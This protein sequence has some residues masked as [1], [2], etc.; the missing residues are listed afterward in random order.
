MRTL[1]SIALTICSIYLSFAQKGFEQGYIIDNSGKQTMGYIK[2]SDLSK[3]NNRNAILEFK[4]QPDADTEKI[5]TTGLTEI[6]VGN[7]HKF[8]KFSLALDDADLYNNIGTN[9][10]PQY[11][12]VEV[13]VTVAIEG[14]AS[15]Y[16]YESSVG[17]KFFFRPNGND[18]IEQLVY[19]KYLTG[20]YSAPRE[21]ATFRQ[22]L[23]DNV[24]CEGDSFAKFSEVSYEKEALKKIFIAYNDCSVATSKVFDEQKESAIHFSAYVGLSSLTSKLKGGTLSAEENSISYDFG[25]EAEYFVIPR[26]LALFGRLGVE[27]MDSELKTDISANG[28]VDIYTAK[29]LIFNTLLGARYYFNP[30]AKTKFFADVAGGI[31][32]PAKSINHGGYI[33]TGET[34]TSFN[35]MNLNTVNGGYLSFSAGCRMLDK[36]GVALRYDLPR[37]IG[38]D[39]YTK[40]SYSRLGINLSYTF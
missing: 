1:L 8:R 6:G 21:N 12:E 38:E 15:L 37:T 19:K 33:I 9:K 3:I 40:F 29:L 36:Y 26:R 22:Q 39:M 27:R 28:R 20:K 32:L 2:I 30:H 17:D 10:Y 13:F 34:Y 7:A 16:V 4:S 23:S 18:K 14:K 11:T 5:Y 35:D 25:I 24:K 31:S